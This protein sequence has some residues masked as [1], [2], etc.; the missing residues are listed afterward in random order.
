MIGLR[1][2]PASCVMRKK[3]LVR[4]PFTIMRHAMRNTVFLYNLTKQTSYK[5]PF[6][7]KDYQTKLIEVNEPILAV[8]CLWI[9]K[10]GNLSASMGAFWF[11]IVN[12]LFQFL[13][14][15]SFHVNNLSMMSKKEKQ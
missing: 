3:S 6:N 14:I 5:F 7:H 15:F 12:P 9:R 11:K 4:T 1:Y 8:N 10:L 13:N 2:K